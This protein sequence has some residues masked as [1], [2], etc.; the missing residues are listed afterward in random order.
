M[1]TMNIM[2]GNFSKKLHGD[3]SQNHHSNTQQATCHFIALLLKKGNILNH[4][5]GKLFDTFSQRDF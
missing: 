4:F 2:F 3:F 5:S 1:Q